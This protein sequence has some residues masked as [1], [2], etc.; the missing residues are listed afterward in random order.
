MKKIIARRLGGSVLAFVLIF[1]LVACGKVPED[2]AG[3]GFKGG[4]P[5]KTDAV[6]PET[7]AVQPETIAV[8]PETTA[9][10][11]SKP[12]ATHSKPSAV[13]DDSLI[14]EAFSASNNEYGAE[15][16]VPKLLSGSADAEEL[17]A[18]LMDFYANSAPAHS[19]TWQSHWSGSLLSLD[20]ISAQPDGDALHNIYYYDFALDK[21]LTYVEMLTRCGFTW[22]SFAPLVLKSAVREHDRLMQAS[23]AEFTRELIADTLSSRS[24]AARAA[25]FASMPF[26][27]NADGT[28]SV[29]LSLPTSAGAG[30]TVKHAIIDPNVKATPLSASYEFITAEVDE[31]GVITVEYSSGGDEFS[32]LD[33][34][35][36][37]G[38]KLDTPYTVDGCFGDYKELYIGNIG[39]DF[40][41]YLLLL[42]EAG[43]LEFVDLFSCARYGEYVC[44]GP[45]YGIQGVVSLSS[46]IVEGGNFYYAT[47]YA[48]DAAGT[49]HD[50]LETLYLYGA[51]PGGMA[52][53]F[54]ADEDGASYEI[55]LGE[56]DGVRTLVSDAAGDRRCTGFPTYL[57]MNAEGLIFELNFW[58][59][60]AHDD[61]AVCALWA[62]DGLLSLTLLSG[63]S[64]FGLAPGEN[65]LFF[66]AWG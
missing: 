23:G 2:T 17:N 26:Y 30:W 1:G 37:Y 24:K 13:Y 66:E 39:S 59:E 28:L 52:R 55:A 40:E 5:T 41:P 4:L 47:V 58:D 33:Y 18:E 22:E 15:I 25:S 36:I 42:T 29:Y 56:E 60:A 21:R 20:M 45:V 57:G 35:R 9:A 61:N 32:G 38:F 51:I 64:P 54:A 62:E 65:M 53:Q 11:P 14:A 6:Q 10:V 27:P 63:E 49:E 16:R 8:Q 31:N 48:R 50:L 19:V 7:T 44:G 3:D 34:Q 12:S 43:T 46:G